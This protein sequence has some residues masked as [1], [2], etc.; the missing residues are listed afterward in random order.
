MMKIAVT[1]DSHT[2]QKAHDDVADDWTQTSEEH[3]QQ[4]NYGEKTTNRCKRYPLSIL[5]LLKKTRYNTVYFHDVKN[6]S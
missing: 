2:I 6:L 3:Q 5:F 1:Y 4:N